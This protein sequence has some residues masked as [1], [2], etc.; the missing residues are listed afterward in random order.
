MGLRGK[1]GK[2]RRKAMRK[3]AVR[4]HGEIEPSFCELEGE[5]PREKPR[6]QRIPTIVFQTAKSA[7]LARRHYRSITE[8]RSLNPDLEFRFYDDQGM[9]EFMASHWGKHEIFDVYE[10]SE[11]PQMRADIFRYC[12]V[13]TYGGYY[14][15]INKAVMARLTSFHDSSATGV[16]SFESNEPERWQSG[17]EAKWLDHPDKVVLQWA[18]GFEEAHPLLMRVISRIVEMSDW[19]AGRSFRQVKSAVLAFT[20]PG[21][22]TAAVV[23]SFREKEL[24][25]VAQAG[26]DFNGHGVFRVPGSHRTPL[27]G[28]HYMELQDRVILRP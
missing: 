16:I 7:M 14:V 8:F 26:I 5:L 24:E 11:F 27:S 23:D 15:D 2:F 28:T 6:L 21:A 3:I 10:R 9:D 20:G 1:L 18:F 22:F 13:Y 4:G 17:P 12:V 19:V 25:G